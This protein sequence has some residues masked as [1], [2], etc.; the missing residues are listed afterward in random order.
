M[1]TVG[2]NVY[3]NVLDDIVDKC[4]NTWHSSIKMKPKDVTDDSLVEHSEESNK[5]DPKFKAGD[6]VRISKYKNI[7]AKGYTPSWSEEIFVVKNIKNTVPWTYVISDLNREEI[8]GSFYE[9]E[10]QKT[11][12]KEFRI[13]KGDNCISN[14]KVMIIFL[15]VGLIKMIL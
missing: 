12:Q 13:E 10:L 6:H 14:G 2:K 3:S 7:F 8:V 11:D 5:K 1:T 9:K 15:T 4:N